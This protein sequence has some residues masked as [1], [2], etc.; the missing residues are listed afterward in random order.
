M[1]EFISKVCVVCLLLLVQK[2]HSLSDV[3]DDDDESKPQK[4]Y[5]FMEGSKHG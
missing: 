2:H 4:F 1:M 3:D 5:G